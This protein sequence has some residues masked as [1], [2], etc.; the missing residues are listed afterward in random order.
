V[1]WK[2]L[3]GADVVDT[4]GWTLLA[5]AYRRLGD[6][7]SA[8][9][10]DG[11]GAA[12]SSTAGVAASAQTQALESVVPS[13]LAPPPE[14]VEIDDE[15]MPR[16]SSALGE[17]L[18]ALGAAGIAPVLDTAGGV[19]VWLAG[20]K[21]VLG[22]G[23]LSV[24]GQA[25]LPFAVALALRLGPEG[26]ALRTPGAPLA[27]F[28]AAVGSAFDASPASLAAARVLAQYEPAV[29]GGD[30]LRVEVGTVLRASGAFRALALRALERLG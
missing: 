1:A 12:L 21:L 4:D 16:L 19:E 28:E 20:Q 27:G 26:A 7:R 18:R 9:L 23:A 2:R 14:L 17:T 3:L 24:F 25:E 15:T 6:E 5:E 29:R 30:P 22:A 10:A 8:T 13:N 11:F